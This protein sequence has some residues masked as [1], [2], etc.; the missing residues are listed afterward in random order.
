MM[1][2]TCT[3]CSTKFV[4]TTEQIG[5]QGKKVRCSKCSHIWHQKSEDNVRIE[6]TLTTPKATTSFGKGVNLPAL[7]PIKFPPYLFVMPILIIGLII[8][9]LTML[10]PNKL[11]VD[12][13]FNS[14]VVSIKD[15]QIVN[16]KD[17]NKITVNYKVHNSSLKKM[18]I[19]FVR[20]RL[21]DK[22][23]K[24]LKSL[25]D[26]HTNIDVSPD[27]SLQVKTEFIPAPRS[28]DKIDIMI[29]NKIDFI[30]Y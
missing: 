17:I 25:I 16:Q 22:N 30:L 8:L 4:V 19:P 10:F 26:N 27:Q 18:K 24:V 13:L 12:S 6:P 3:K 23:N 29:G 11:G 14:N 28:V 20:I 15:L 1:Y 9:M 21:L 7:L 2:I 5:E